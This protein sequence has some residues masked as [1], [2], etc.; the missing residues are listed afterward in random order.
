MSMMTDLRKLSNHPLLLRYHY[1]TTQLDEMAVLLAKDPLYK[2]TV[3]D[4]IVSDLMCMSDFELH[5]LTKYYRCLNDFMLPDNLIM[6]SG[7]F[8]Y[9][10]KMLE[11]LK[12]NGNRVLI[13][14]QYV[15][16]LNVMEEYLRLKKYK[17]LRLDG[18]TTVS[19]RYL[20]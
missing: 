1:D 7:K 8:S 15:I 11:S 16:M 13:F 10:D 19:D 12:M 17:F 9:L 3:I 6:T 4:Y 20:L 2:D 18:S 5:Q 14:S